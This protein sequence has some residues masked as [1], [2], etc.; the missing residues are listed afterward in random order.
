MACFPKLPEECV[1][2]ILCQ[3][4]PKDVCRMLV[5]SKEFR[6]P[7]ESDVVWHQ[8]LPTDCSHINVSST[9][10]SKKELFFLLSH[11]YILIDAGYKAFKLEKSTG[12][13]SYILS[14][15]DL[16]ILHG[17]DETNWTWKCIQESTF[18]EVA[19]LKT[20]ER[21]EIQGKIRAQ[22]LSPNT[23]YSAY[24]I[25]KLSNHAYGLD[26][27]PCEVYI[28]LNDT[29]L[30]ANTARLRNPDDK[31][32][33]LQSLFYGNRMQTMKERVIGGDEKMAGER[34]DGWLEIEVG[35]FFVGESDEEIEMNV[36]EVKGYQLK[37]GLI[38]E[39]IEVRPKP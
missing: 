24:L 35:E 32:Q 37:G 29:I 1:S 21:L 33:H 20:V 31:K 2:W 5:V 30:K 22:T 13:K 11:Q 12:R 14:A 8:F 19:E 17:D 25:F 26:S 6:N 34:E 39:G 27:I 7:A 23:H 28:T 4:S 36:M 18:G 9:F 16:S 3:T 38:V 15:R 10:S